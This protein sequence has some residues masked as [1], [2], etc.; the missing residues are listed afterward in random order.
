MRT[1]SFR[2]WTCMRQGPSDARPT[3]THGL[4]V[5]R[6]H[7]QV[8]HAPQQLR[9]PRPGGA[10]RFDPLRFARR[11]CRCQPGRWRLG[12]FAKKRGGGPAGARAGERPCHAAF[13]W[14][15]AC[16]H[17]PCASAGTTVSCCRR[18]RHRPGRP[19]EVSLWQ[20]AGAGQLMP[21]ESEGTGGD[22]AWLGGT[23]SQKSSLQ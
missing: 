8:P 19:G 2:G 9:A 13:A 11:A 14:S 1:P 23:H 6:T 22:R 12:F 16:R 5:C 3:G 21:K 10:G 20:R 4:T 15:S 17:L 7:A 18:P